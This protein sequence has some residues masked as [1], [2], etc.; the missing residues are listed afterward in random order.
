MS[1]TKTKFYIAALDLF[2][3]KYHTVD[4]FQAQA[5]KLMRACDGDLEKL[6]KMLD[7]K[8]GK[9][10][11]KHFD[12]LLQYERF[13]PD[14]AEKQFEHSRGR[15][16]TNPSKAITTN[17][18]KATLKVKTNKTARSSFLAPNQR[19]PA[20]SLCKNNQEFKLGQFLSDLTSL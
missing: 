13:M 20:F 17:L 16:T 11:I 9:M 8:L 6:M 5:K 7:F 12:I 1:S 4:F 18:S 15:V 19:P 3:N 2:S 10:Y 14:K